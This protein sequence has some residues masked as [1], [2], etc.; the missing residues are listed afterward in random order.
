MASRVVRG[1]ADL[2]RFA[3]IHSSFTER[4]NGSGNYHPAPEGN[5]IATWR[6][7]AIATSRESHGENSRQDR[8]AGFITWAGGSKRSGLALS[9]AGRLAELFENLTSRM[10]RWSATLPAVAKWSDIS[11]V[12]PTSVFKKA[13][14]IEA[15]APVMVKSDKN[16]GDLPISVFDDLRGCYWQACAIL[17]GFEPPV[18]WLPNSAHSPPHQ[19]NGKTCATKSANSAAPDSPR[20]KSS[21]LCRHMNFSPVSGHQQRKLKRIE[22][23]H[24][25]SQQSHEK[26]VRARRGRRNCLA[27]VRARRPGM[28]Y[29]LAHRSSTVASRTKESPEPSPARPSNTPATRS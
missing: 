10:P 28:D 20:R 26:Q 14:L 17:P 16:P 2:E 29:P 13:V 8:S 21:T 24:D 9:E 5:A 23:H 25:R 19:R 7:N 11:V 22:N 6:F 4:A 15:I 1:L 3:R 18:L 27:R 12:T